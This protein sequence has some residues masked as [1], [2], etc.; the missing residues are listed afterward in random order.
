MIPTN[1]VMLIH[2][3]N[4]GSPCAPLDIGIVAGDTHKLSTVVFSYG[5]TQAIQTLMMSV[6]FGPTAHSHIVVGMSVGSGGVFVVVLVIRPV[7]MALLIV[8]GVIL[9]ICAQQMEAT[10]ALLLS[11]NTTKTRSVSRALWLNH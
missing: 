2:F 1:N 7:I 5:R 6:E 3:A 4:T 8:T 11:Q 9:L 10:V